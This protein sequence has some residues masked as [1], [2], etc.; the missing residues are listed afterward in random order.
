MIRLAIPADALS[1]AERHVFADADLHARAVA[2]YDA[3]VRKERVAHDVIDEYDFR[4]WQ[5][6]NVVR[7]LA[8]LRCLVVRGNAFPSE[9]HITYGAATAALRWAEEPD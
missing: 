1:A 4:Y 6:R 5:W 9:G 8:V 3:A 2:C 7:K